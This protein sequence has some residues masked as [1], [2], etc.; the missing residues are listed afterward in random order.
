MS[1]I[2][3]DKN[4]ESYFDYLEY[5][6]KYSHHTVINYKDDVIEY[7]EFLDSENLTYKSIRYEDIRFIY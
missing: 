6:K 3:L 1:D 2:K 4:V 5:E 7:L